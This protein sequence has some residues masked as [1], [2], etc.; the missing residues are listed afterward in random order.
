MLERY[1][2]VLVIRIDGLFS[3]YSA[4]LWSMGVCLYYLTFGKSPI[5]YTN[6]IDLITNIKSYNVLPKMEGISVDLENLLSA[7]LNPDVAERPC[8]EDIMVVI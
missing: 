2:T 1:S 7:M 8:L 3:S 5:L 6:I 4:D